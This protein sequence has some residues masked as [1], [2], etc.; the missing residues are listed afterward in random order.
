MKEIWAPIKW[1]GVQLYASSTGQIKDAKG[2]IK[3]QNE[4]FR[5]NRINV[6]GKHELVHRIIATAFIPNPYNLE[7][8][9][10]IDGN[11]KNNCSENLEWCTR[12]EN[13][14]KASGRPMHSCFI[15]QRNLSG[16]LISVFPSQR[17]AAR[18][19]GIHHEAIN[20]CCTGRRKT[21]GG[22]CWNYTN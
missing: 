4:S 6:K 8:V 11:K 10:H 15:E 18:V 3:H 9:N 12:Q 13:S 19:T 5:Y 1:N 21:A 16:E 17:E 7:T 20:M 2:R 22:F 14:L